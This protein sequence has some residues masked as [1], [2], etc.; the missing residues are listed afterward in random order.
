MRRLWRHR[1]SLKRYFLDTVCFNETFTD[2]TNFQIIFNPRAPLVLLKFDRQL[3]VIIL[4]GK[5]RDEQ[6][7][8]LF[9]YQVYEKDRFLETCQWSPDGKLLLVLSKITAGEVNY[10]FL[11]NFT[12]AP[13]FCGPRKN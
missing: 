13:F 4:P 3:W 11:P 7:Q 6:G 1:T 2:C 5:R 9:N 12:L 8:I 10:F